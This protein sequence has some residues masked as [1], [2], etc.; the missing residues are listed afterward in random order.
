MEINGNKKNADGCPQHMCINCNKIYVT[1]SGLWKHSQKCISISHPKKIDAEPV[2][3]SNEPIK[4]YIMQMN[5]DFKNEIKFLLE[6]QAKQI[7]ITNNNTTNNNTN[8][9]NNT[10]FNLNVFL[11][12]KCKDALNMEDFINTL[13]I[14][15]DSVE[16][17]GTHGYVNGITKIFMDGLNELDVYKRPIHCTDLKRDVLYIK[18][19][20]KWQKDNENNTKFRQA[21]DTVVNRNMA[22]VRVWEE[23]N[24]QC[25]IP[26]TEEYEF[27]F[28]IARQ[29]LG[30]GDQKVTDRN[31]DKIL[32]AVAKHVCI[33][34]KYK[35]IT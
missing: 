14:D 1:H 23:E 28:V 22:Q 33:D 32:K 16:Y 12:E 20:D 9:Q 17:T 2:V 4:N 21:L 25:K 3:A 31:N 11:Q 8:I 15:A 10:Q 29:S 27:Y 24:P 18:E 19:E 26:E 30:G 5:A 35:E 34:K 13:K 7:M 6:E